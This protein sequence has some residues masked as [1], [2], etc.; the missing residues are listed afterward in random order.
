MF[1]NRKISSARSKRQKQPRPCKSS[2]SFPPMKTFCCHFQTLVDAIC[3]VMNN[4]PG[5]F[6]LGYLVHHHIAYYTVQ[7][8]FN[9]L[10]LALLAK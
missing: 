3:K 6:P 5:A 2:K 7:D 10:Y 8:L 4:L 9:V 1:Q